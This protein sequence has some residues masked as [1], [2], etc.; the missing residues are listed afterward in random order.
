MNNTYVTNQQR[1]YSQFNHINEYFKLLTQFYQ[2]WSLSN[3]C[4]TYYSLDIENSHIDDDKLMNGSYELVGDLS[5]YRWR[6]ILKLEVNNIEQTMTTPTADEKGVTYSEKLT[7]CWIPSNDQIE[8]HVHDFVVFSDCQD[9]DNYYLRNPP[10]FEVVNVEKSPDFD[11]A[12]YKVMLKVTYLSQTMLDNQITSLLYYSD[13]EKGLYGI[14]DSICLETLLSERS[15]NKCNYF[16]N[17]NTGL[18]FDKID[19]T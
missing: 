14:D 4:V 17:K 11:C 1:F 7:S 10:V 8:C 2:N 13:Y 9:S 16:H 6:K 19:F 3:A 18:Y 12:F 5:G 15:K